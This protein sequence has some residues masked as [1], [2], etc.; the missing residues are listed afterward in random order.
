MNKDATYEI[1]CRTISQMQK[2]TPD[3]LVKAT[4]SAGKDQEDLA[5][6]LETRFPGITKDLCRRY[7]ETHIEP[8][9]KDVL[10]TDEFSVAA[11]SDPLR[12]FCTVDPQ[13]ARERCVMHFINAVN[14]NSSEHLKRAMVA[15]IEFGLGDHIHASRAAAFA[16]C[17][18]REPRFDEWMDVDSHPEAMKM[19]ITTECEK[20]E[21]LI[22]FMM[23]HRQHN[24]N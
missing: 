2:L 9:L 16:V 4:A 6:H 22:A 21:I 19:L 18:L 24:A 14:E 11:L 17:L 23:A 8:M 7:M 3:D 5:Q 1:A 12:T 10:P 20:A 15:R 13:I